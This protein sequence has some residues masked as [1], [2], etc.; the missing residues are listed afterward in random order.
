[1]E[2]KAFMKIIPIFYV[3]YYLLSVISYR[4]MF[5]TN[6]SSFQDKKFYSALKSPIFRAKYR[7]GFKNSFAVQK[8][9]YN[10]GIA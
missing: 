9:L 2:K 7:P 1:V 5:R 6:L 8:C 3:V 10:L 4:Y